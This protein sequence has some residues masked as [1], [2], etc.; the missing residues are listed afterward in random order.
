M[1]NARLD[2]WQRIINVSMI[3]GI[4]VSRFMTVFNNHVTSEPC[5]LMLSVI[6]TCKLYNVTFRGV[7]TDCYFGKV[8]MYLI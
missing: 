2:R 6:V 8:V 3:D 1:Y 4:D 7:V 5:P